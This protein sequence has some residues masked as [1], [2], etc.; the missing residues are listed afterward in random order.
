MVWDD[1]CSNLRQSGIPQGGE[2]EG[3]KRAYRRDRRHRTEPEKPE[4]YR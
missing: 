3:A 2:G 4:P 1:P